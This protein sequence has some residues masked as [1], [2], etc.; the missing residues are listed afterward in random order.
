MQRHFFRAA[1]RLLAIALGL[2]VVIVQ[3]QYVPADADGDG[4]PDSW[5]MQYLGTLAYGAGD[6]PG[7]VGQTL[8]QSYQQGLSPWP[9]ATVANGLRAWYR[10]DLG[11]VPDGSDGVSQWTDL[12]GNGVHLTQGDSTKEP[13]WSGVTVNGEPALTF[14]GVGTALAT[15]GLVDVLGG[16]SELTVVVALQPASTQPYASTI[17]D[18]DNVAFRVQSGSGDQFGASWWNPTLGSWG[19]G[20]SAALSAGLP[21]IFTLTKTVTELKS[22]VDGTQQ[23]DDSGWG[24]GL[25]LLQ[26]GARS[27]TLGAMTN[28]VGNFNGQIAEVLIYNHAL[29]DTERQQVEQA[30]TAR[31][32]TSSGPMDSDGNGLPD[33]WEMQYFG[34][35]GVDPSADSDGDGVPN[36]SEYQLGSDPTDYF[37]GRV[38]QILIT[39]GDNQTGFAGQF[40]PLPLTV[41]VENSADT[42]P[43]ANAPVAFTVDAGEGYLATSNLGGISG[44]ATLTVRTDANGFAQVYFS[45]PIALGVPSLIHA[46]AGGSQQVAFHSVSATRSVLYSCDFET[47]EGYSVGPVSNQGSWFVFLGDAETSTE[48]AISGS[49]SMAIEPSA[50][51]GTFAYLPFSFNQGGPIA[52]VDF[53]AKPIASPDLSNNVISSFATDSAS[54]YLKQSGALG[55]VYVYDGDGSSGKGYSGTGYIVPL[56]QDGRS[57][58]WMRF[59]IRADYSAQRWD[60]FVD[61]RLVAA[62]VL[63]GSTSFNQL[64]NFVVTSVATTPLYFDRLTISNSN[65]LFADTNNDG[66]DDAWELSHG[67]S[68]SVDN[69]Q[70]TALDGVSWLTKYL[71]ENAD[72]DGNGLNDSWEIANFGHVGV[73]PNDDPDGDGQTNL[74]EAMNGTDPSNFN[75]VPPPSTPANVQITAVSGNSITLSW[76]ASTAAAGRTVTGYEIFLNEVLV[77]QT[78]ATTAAVTYDSSGTQLQFF[79]VRSVDSAQAESAASAEILAPLPSTATD[80]TIQVKYAVGRN[81]AKPG[82]VG[83]GGQYYLGIQYS[84]HFTDSI[85]MG[86]AEVG[87]YDDQLAMVDEL[88][89][90][91]NQWS[92]TASGGIQQSMT[93]SNGGVHNGD[94]GDWTSTWQMDGSGS[95][96]VAVGDAAPA[97]YTAQVPH[98]GVFVPNAQPTEDGSG[99]EGRIDLSGDLANSPGWT[100]TETDVYTATYS[101]VYEDGS[102]QGTAN[103]DYALAIGAVT[104][105]PWPTASGKY[106][107]AYAQNGA[108]QSSG[109]TTYAAS[110]GAPVLHL[111]GRVVDL[112]SQGVITAVQCYGSIY[113]LHSNLA[114]PV[115]FYWA[116]I[117]YPEHTTSQGGITV[118]DGPPQITTHDEVAYGDQVSGAFTQDHSLSPPAANGETDVVLLNASVDTSVASSSQ[119]NTGATDYL[120]DTGQVGDVVNLLENGAQWSNA[121]SIVVNYSGDSDKVK[122]LV[123]DPQTVADVGLLGAVGQGVQVASGLDL[124]SS[125]HMNW[126]L[127]VVGSSP[128]VLTV[129]ITLTVNG[130]PFSIDKMITIL[131]QTEAQ[132]VDRDD[133]SRTWTNA[134]VLSQG[135]VLYAGNNS[136]D[137]VSWKVSHPE[138][139]PGATYTW[140]AAGPNQA[141]IAGP[142]GAN[143]SEWRLANVGA[144]Y[145]QPFVNWNPGHYMITCEIQ[146]ESG[147]TMTLYF[148][149]NI[150]WR[151]EHYLVAGQ[152]L[153]VT[154]FTITDERKDALKTALLNDL[155]SSIVLGTQ[156]PGLQSLMANLSTEN[157]AKIWFMITGGLRHKRVADLP[158][159]SD[160]EKLWL[161]QLMLDDGPDS[162]PLT[163][164]PDTSILNTGAFNQFLQEESYRMFSGFQVKYLWE[165]G[166]VANVQSLL[167]PDCKESVAGPTKIGIPAGALVSVLASVINSNPTSVRVPFNFNKNQLLIPSDISPFNGQLRVDH[168]GGTISLYTSGRISFEG[169]YPNYALFSRDVPFIFNEI[170]FS[171]DE[172]GRDTNNHVRTS[173]DRDWKQNGTLSGVCQFNAITILQANDSGRYFQQVHLPIEDHAGM[174]Q[175]FINSLP[176]G[177]WPTTPTQPTTLDLP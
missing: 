155:F 68:L 53:Y 167:G 158:G 176:A 146:L 137:M 82:I 6:D 149:E 56:D 125:N 34:H 113:R 91:T 83:P 163:I 159:I 17:L 142:S 92:C 69:R 115:H 74:V 165:N 98:L 7:G 18:F 177:T 67:L 172:N 65:P 76:I 174:L 9:A 63:P 51:S 126:P 52:Y 117:F 148:P 28:Q 36:F 29:S 50:P 20:G 4:L 46:V 102:V 58:N 162:S 138:Q 94:V 123:L 133:G 151:T 3:A 32:L 31:Y 157:V 147:S 96:A 104:S 23:S 116:E 13:V 84:H 73:D 140:T 90:T 114:G 152:V 85:Q 129:H 97:Q 41:L 19:S 43:L 124:V 105:I 143:A 108:L 79:T 127:V 103:S 107:Y 88:D 47:S 11:V 130:A 78:S 71:G 118:S 60:L 145:N 166:K 164:D 5:E 14:D 10:A 39:G 75:D 42:S 112:N 70:L 160:S 168:A 30:L 45:Q 16:S 101:D 111:A 128:G 40:N 89:T 93:V 21:Q 62:D 110:D 12:S 161:V 44:Q 22:Y 119:N 59:T 35:L 2:L 136:G 81:E 24:D 144:T 55:E 120:P 150:G 135:Q 109:V 25:G 54:I 121:S 87:T 15:P 106:A 153:P 132:F 86:G 37:N 154:D 169:Q 66:I 141:I 170:V 49:Q 48:D 1:I 38:P 8:L 77:K 173:V 100:Y 139:M 27:M 171:V 64:V 156:A 99:F 33:D 175:P 80:G 95:F 131:P 61:G 57:L 72:S 134:E 26:Q 122:V